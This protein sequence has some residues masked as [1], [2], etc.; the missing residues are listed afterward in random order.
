MVGALIS[1]HSA[2]KSE[3]GALV[4]PNA[5]NALKQPLDR[6]TSGLATFDDGLNNI[7]RKVGK[8][9]QPADMGLVELELPGNLHRV[10]IFSATKVSHP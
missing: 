1:R 9:Q 4:S 3:C 6:H 7:G 8:S 10:G 5:G 2:C